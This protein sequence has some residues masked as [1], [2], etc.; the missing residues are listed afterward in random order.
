MS[1]VNKM[2]EKVKKA[3]E[4]KWTK[5]LMCLIVP[6]LF[7]IIVEGL[8]G[9]PLLMNRDVTEE[10]IPFEQIQVSNFE[11]EQESLVAREDGSVIVIE[12]SQSRYINKLYLSFT[13]CKSLLYTMTTVEDRGGGETAIRTFHRNANM[14]QEFTAIPLQKQ[15][16]RVAI[17][18][19]IE[20][21]EEVAIHQIA[22]NNEFNFSPWRFF[23]AFVSLLL[24]LLILLFKSEFIGKEERFFVVAGILMGMVAITSMPPH[25]SGWDEEIHFKRTY[26]FS[27][28]MRFQREFEVSP[29]VII[30]T[31]NFAE[32]WPFHYPDTMEDRRYLAEKY[33]EFDHNMDWGNEDTE[34]VRRTGLGFGNFVNF[35]LLAPGYITQAAFVTIGR[36]LQLPFSMVYM[37]GRLGNLLMYLIVGYFAI[38]RSIVG[39]K[40]M[41]ALLL[42]P[43]PLFLATVYSYD[44]TTNVFIA[45]GIACILREIYG[46]QEKISYVNVGIFVASIVIASM[47]KA[48]FAPL[49]LL[50]LLI[51]KEKLPSVKHFRLM[52][53][54]IVGGTLILLATFV[55]PTLI[56]TLLATE[57][58]IA[59]VADVRGGD[60]NVVR[61]M[62]H[63]LSRPF[64]YAIGVLQIM[65]GTIVEFSIG[66]KAMG[67]VGH[68]FSNSMSGAPAIL[69]AAVTFTENG[70]VK[71]KKEHKIFIA[72]ILFVISALIWTALY[73]SF[74]PVGHP[75]IVGVQGR[76]F[77]PLVLIGLLLINGRAVEYKCDEK[78]YNTVLFTF[79]GLITLTS[80][81]STFVVNNM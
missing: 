50:G 81:Y 60:T 49:L 35:V 57:A 78:A 37:M 56:D 14:F 51:P 13:S 47:P 73:L 28:T 53:T 34:F 19:E 22:I 76:Y 45:L 75:Y 68:G 74:T 67:L 58:S 63:I 15:I 48:I 8:S 41:T 1:G 80:F 38:R 7:A 54:G 21:G 5:A 65:Y 20:E 9:L 3:L 16:Y 23:F 6:L 79:I 25:T 36:V 71:I 32:S 46:K 10:I 61:Q 55:L 59:E 39:K 69:L 4:K 42:M 33:N 31:G 30:M 77:I 17:Q 26:S 27:N 29:T 72:M 11:Q 43:T 66:S 62:H 24:L 52:R 44:A 2:V 40:I 64:S 70:F 12:F 18:F